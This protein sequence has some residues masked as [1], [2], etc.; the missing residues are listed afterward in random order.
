[1]WARRGNRD[2]GHKFTSQAGKARGEGV[3]GWGQQCRLLTRGPR[4]WTQPLAGTSVLLQAVCSSAS[5]S[6][7]QCPVCSLEHASGLWGP[8]FPHRDNGEEEG[9]EGCER[10]QSQSH[11]PSEPL[12]EVETLRSP[13][14]R[15]HGEELMC[16]FGD[17]PFPLGSPPSPPSSPLLPRGP[18]RHSPTF[19]LALGEVRRARGSAHRSTGPMFAVPRAQDKRRPALQTETFKDYRSSYRLLTKDVLASSSTNELSQQ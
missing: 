17:F 5:A 2:V 8:Q 3:A 12:P 14:F 6:G 18:R 4:W 11:I 1:M 9:C 16:R 7:H 13:T 19:P 10:F 15:N